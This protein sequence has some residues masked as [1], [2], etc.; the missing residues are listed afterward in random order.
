MSHKGIRLLIKDVAQSL[1]DDI[2]FTYARPSD[3]NVMRDK[4]YPFISMD[5]LSSSPAYAVDNVQNY[6]KTWTVQMAFYQLDNESST[7]DEYSQILDFTDDLV[8]NF[9]NKLNFYSLK[10]DQ[11]LITNIGQTGFV[12]VMA[13]ILT[14]HILTFNIQAMD[15]FNYCGLNDC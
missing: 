2:Q 8:D 4:R 9:I 13:D 12:K 7:Q 5:L 15:D 3:F 1:G 10:S 6:T 14:G 11:I